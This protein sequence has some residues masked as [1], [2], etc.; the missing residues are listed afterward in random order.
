[1][2][3]RTPL[4]AANKTQRWEGQTLSNKTSVMTDKFEKAIPTPPHSHN[5]FWSGSSLSWSDLHMPN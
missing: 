2:A 3:W 5:G 1:M 4:H